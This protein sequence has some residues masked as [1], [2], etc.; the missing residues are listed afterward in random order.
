MESEEII[1]QLTGYE[2]TTCSCNTCKTMCKTA[3]CIGTPEEMIKIIEA[4]FVS[5]LIVT[6][7][8]AGIKYGAPA[9]DIIAPDFNNGRCAFLNE[10]DLCELHDLKLKPAE[11]C[12]AN[13][14]HTHIKD[15]KMHPVVAILFTWAKDID[16]SAEAFFKFINYSK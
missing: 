3:P 10:N 5:K 12:F 14:N 16:K 7:Y 4:G 15:G 1:K 2:P 6:G 9:M 8:A 13:C 11:G